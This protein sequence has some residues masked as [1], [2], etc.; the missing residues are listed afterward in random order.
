MKPCRSCTMFA[1]FAIKSVCS[2]LCNCFSCF[3]SSS[4]NDYEYVN[5]QRTSKSFGKIEG[6]D[7]CWSHRIAIGEWTRNELDTQ[8]VYSNVI[9]STRLKPYAIFYDE[10]IDEVIL[11]IRGTLSFEDCI[12]DAL[13]EPVRIPISSAGEILNHNL[14]IRSSSSCIDDHDV[15]EKVVCQS[16]STSDSLSHSNST[17]SLSGFAAYDIVDSRWAHEGMLLSALA[18]REDIEKKGLLSSLSLNRLA[19]SKSSL[20]GHTGAQ[21]K[22]VICGHSLGAGIASILSLLYKSEY[23]NLHCYTYGIPGSVVDRKTADD[24]IPYV[25]N[26]ILD[27]DMI[28]RISFQ[29]L[30]YL[31]TSILDSIIRACANKMEIFQSALIS[32]DKINLQNLMDDVSE[33]N[34]YNSE[35]KQ[36]IVH[37]I[38]SL[39]IQLILFALS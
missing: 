12:T 31:K 35:F 15:I 4:Y 19:N 26:V 24:M 34:N 3:V 39:L 7:P 32:S 25:T 17:N 9:N 37:H 11:A 30:L 8:L 2:K 33:V 38:V 18:I 14:N 16:S 21:F 20:T 28:S 6:S 10:S 27:N 22:F 13:A 1:W 5:G 23:P 29:S 36:N